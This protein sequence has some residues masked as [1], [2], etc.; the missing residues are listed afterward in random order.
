MKLKN[1]MR[2]VRLLCL[3]FTFKSG[4]VFAI[5]PDSVYLLS[6]ATNKHNNTVGL[7]FAWSQDRSSWHF[8]G[9]DFGFLRSDYSRWGTEKKMIDPFL[10]RDKQGKWRCIWTLNNRDKA[11]AHAESSDLLEW[12]RQSYPSIERGKNFST[13]VVTA[14]PGTNKYLI[15]YK[16]T[17]NNYYDAVTAD[18]N[19]YAFGNSKPAKDPRESV[20]VEGQTLRGQVHR[21]SWKDVDRMIRHYELTRLKNK[22]YGETAANYASLFPDLKPV[23]ASLQVANAE[24]KEIGDM[25][26][27]V[28]FEDINYAADGGLYGELIQNR[29]FEYSLSDKEGFDKNW[30]HSFAWV[31]SGGVSLTIDTVNAIHPNNLHYGV[32]NVSDR[33]SIR[34]TG[35]DGIVVRKGRKYDVSFFARRISARATPCTV[36]L[37]RPDGEVLA[38]FKTSI[39]SVEWKKTSAVLNAAADEDNAQLEIEIGA[40]G[41]V[42]LDMISLFPKDTFKGRKNGLRSDLAMAMEGLHPRFMRFPGGCVAHG[43]G[44]NNIYHWKNTIGPLEARKP[45]RNLW[46]YH[47]T[48]GLGYFEYFQF[49][50]DIGAAPVPVVAAGVPCQ[51]SAHGGQQGGI[52]MEKMGAY[53]QDIL[54][55]IEYANGDVRSTWGKKRAEAGHPKPFGLKYIGIGNEDLITDVF[56]ERFTMIYDA[57]K[58]R[59]P[60]I[61]VIGTVGPAAQGTDYREGWSIANHLKLKMVDEHYYQ[62]PGWFIYNQD[63]YDSYDRTKAKVYLGE[64]AAHLPGRPNNIE[65][66]LAEGLYLTALERNGDVVSM[67]S[68]APLL[69]KDG[70]T[71][72]NPNMIYFNNREV[73]L[74]PGYYVQKLFAEHSG[75][76]YITSSLS[77]D[78]DSDPVKKRIGLSIVKDSKTN[79]L[80]VKMVNLLPQ[81]AT[82]DLSKTEL[83]GLRGKKIILQGRPDEKQTVPTESAFTV[84]ESSISLPAFSLTVLRLRTAQ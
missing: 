51:N 24:R 41:D 7:Q 12:G 20:M 71:Q 61:I 47:Q 13:S 76:Q 19:Q 39:A 40:T 38:Q 23:Q 34:N 67:A 4:L 29:D 5:A 14:E 26:V 58:K 82:I 78:S 9:N 21:V 30:N 59:Y 63:Y 10:F 27:G 72:W 73:R 43:D 17:D 80:I 6:F 49:C 75:D 18:F 53:I 25:L 37:V 62:T 54:D 36:K 77:V 45:Q 50:E 46:G 2:S 84:S 74:T 60:E 64:Y 15:H 32:L 56:E 83:T 35:F 69:A 55:L 48:V 70:H 33:G 22:L 81:S 65:T 66:A 79:D 1:K 44:L 31:T 52:P 11:F 68:Y 42:A 28:F 8:I 3:L 16:D 57:V